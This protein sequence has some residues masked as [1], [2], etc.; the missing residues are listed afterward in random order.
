MPSCF[1]TGRLAI[2][3]AS[4]CDLE[5]DRARIVGIEQRHVAHRIGRDADQI[6]RAIG[7]L[8]IDQVEQHVEIGGARLLHA[9]MAHEAAGVDAALQP[10][11]DFEEAPAGDAVH[12][13]LRQAGNAG[14]GLQ[15]HVG[16]L[17]DFGLVKRPAPILQLLAEFDDDAP[18]VA[19]S[20][21]RMTE[22]VRC[23]ARASA[24]AEPYSSSLNKAALRKA[25]G[26]SGAFG[27]CVP[28]PSR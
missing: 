9:E 28:R 6:A 22:A 10:A 25:C 15:R 2:C 7:D 18:G 26:V 24:T 17:E 3:S 19:E 14:D 13:L 4:R 12:V 23:E 5:G 16:A 21:S 27:F 11:A 8:R 1:S 20:R